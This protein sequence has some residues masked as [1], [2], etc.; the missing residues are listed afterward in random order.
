MCKPTAKFPLLRLAYGPHSDD[1]SD[2]WKQ[3]EWAI[4]KAQENYVGKGKRA[5][6][7]KYNSTTG[8]K[9][10]NYTKVHDQMKG[11]YDS[12]AR[13]LSYPQMAKQFTSEKVSFDRR[14][15]KHYKGKRRCCFKCNK[16]GDHSMDVCRSPCASCFETTCNKGHAK[17]NAD[18]HAPVDTA[19]PPA[20]RANAAIAATYVEGGIDVNFDYAGPVE[21]YRKALMGGL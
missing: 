19:D 17:C 9:Q 2:H 5:G 14:T 8:G 6:E 21:T 18:M 3:W 20:D 12:K 11:C 13:S 4:H 1:P 16:Y 15:K 7:G 10:T